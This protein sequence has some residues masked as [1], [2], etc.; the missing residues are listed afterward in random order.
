MEIWNKSKK[1]RVAK[2]VI[3]R[4]SFFELVAGLI[5]YKAEKSKS[6]L[7]IFK[8]KVF[9]EDQ[10]MLFFVR[11][12]SVHSFFMNFPIVVVFLD[13]QLK[14]VDV[15][16]LKPF[17]I[18]RASKEFECFLELHESKEKLIEV[19]DLLIFK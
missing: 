3:V 5:P 1:V 10:A 19:G 7:D 15:K 17:S 11:D 9:R 13:K 6:F 16:K 8:F 4:K 14:V 12:G 2:D 18:V